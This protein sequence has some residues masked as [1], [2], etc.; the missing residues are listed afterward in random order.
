MTPLPPGYFRGVVEW[1]AGTTERF[2]WR[3]G[4]IQP[5]RR[6]PLAAPVNYGCL[7]GL[8]N[9]ADHAE[10]DAVW[11]GQARPVGTVVEAPPT[12]L[13]HLADGDHKVIFGELGGAAPL[14]SWFPPQRQAQLLGHAAAL[15]WLATLNK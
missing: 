2:V 11:L 1:T 5:Y 7:P 4:Q 14:L 13:L 9:P 12:G 8:L 15:A 10:V 6:E 3:G